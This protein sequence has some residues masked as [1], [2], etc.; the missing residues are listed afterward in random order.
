MNEVLE[1]QYKQRWLDKRDNLSMDRS[2]LIAVVVS[3]HDTCPTTE[4]CL[5]RSY[6]GDGACRCIRTVFPTPEHYRLY[7][8]LRKLLLDVELVNAIKGEAYAYKEAN[9]GS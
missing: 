9:E 8:S 1:E 3:G 5:S 7:L 4:P 6:S 2:K